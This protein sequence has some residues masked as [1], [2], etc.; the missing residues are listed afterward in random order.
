MSSFVASSTTELH[1]HGLVDL[2]VPGEARRAAR[3][4]AIGHGHVLLRLFGAPAQRGDGPAVL[5][6]VGAGNPVERVEGR[7]AQGGDPLALVFE[8]TA[9][10]AVLPQRRRAPRYPQDREVRLERE[11]TSA[12]GRVVDLSESGMRFRSAEDYR[13]ADALTVDLDVVRGPARVVRVHDAGEYALELTAW[14]EAD[15]ARLRELLRPA[16]PAGRVS[17]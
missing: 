13:P 11:G 17:R 5:E 14:P 3:V 1:E 8:P 12:V 7:L 9:P 10:D 4:S 15:V 6:L 2:L 16:R